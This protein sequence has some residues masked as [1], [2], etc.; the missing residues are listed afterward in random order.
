[1]QATPRSNKSGTKTTKKSQTIQTSEVNRDSW[2]DEL[3]DKISLFDA[4]LSEFF[5]KL[6]PS[7]GWFMGA[8]PW[9]DPTEVFATVPKTKKEIDTYDHIVSF[10][11]L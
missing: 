8:R 3:K 2:A 11:C 5:N 4:P 1:M 6:V 10:S 9:S 7:T